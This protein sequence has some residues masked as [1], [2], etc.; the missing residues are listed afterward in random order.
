MAWGWDGKARTHTALQM[1]CGGQSTGE[2][3]LGKLCL[4]TLWGYLGR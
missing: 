1:L 3:F 4:Q 2:Q